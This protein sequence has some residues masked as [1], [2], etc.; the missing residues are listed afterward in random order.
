MNSINPTLFFSDQTSGDDSYQIYVNSDKFSIYEQ[1]DN[2]YRLTIDGSGNVGIGTSNP[3]A[4]LHV[5]NTNVRFGDFVPVTTHS[6]NG[7]FFL[8]DG[9]PETVVSARGP[10]P[11]QWNCSFR[12]NNGQP[13][14]KATVGGAYSCDSGW[15][16]DTQTECVVNNFGTRCEIGYNSVGLTRRNSGAWE[17]GRAWGEIEQGIAAPVLMADSLCLGGEC[18][19]EWS[20]S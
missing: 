10:L 3:Q 17:E 20:C 2:A 18:R 11:V 8:K 14:L 12:I 13:Q 6:G 5:S 9:Y 19:A 16:S 15:D 4:K 7:L 1:E